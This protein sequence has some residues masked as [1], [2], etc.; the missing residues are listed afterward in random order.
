MLAE[1]R[2]DGLIRVTA[3][4]CPNTERVGATGY[5]VV[6]RGYHGTKDID[7]VLREGLRVDACRPGPCRHICVSDWP[8]VA[9]AFGDVVVVELDGLVDE[10]IGGE[11]R[12]H[13]DVPAE[14][15]SRFTDPVVPSLAKHLDPYWAYPAVRN[16][17]HCWPYLPTGR[18]A[19]AAG[20]DPTPVP[21][22]S[23]E[24]D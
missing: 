5:N 1:Q 23:D 4:C 15:I 12:I 16:H 20:V 11:A 7:A 6:V 22:T 21:Y 14:R 19:L 2:P 24:V 9:A 10:I 18:E 3:R 17:P 8:E 13:V